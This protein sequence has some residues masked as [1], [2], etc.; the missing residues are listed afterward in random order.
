MRN[1][2]FI[3]YNIDTE[4]PLYESLTATFERINETFGLSIE[5]TI[6]NLK[7]LQNGVSPQ[8]YNIEPKILNSIKKFVSPKL[9]NHKNDW[10]ELKKMWDIAFSDNFRNN[11]LFLDSK[12]QGIIYN[13]FI[14]DHIGFSDVN[15]RRRT[16]G[17]NGVFD[18]YYDLISQSKSN[19]K[20]YW[21]FHPLHFYKQANYCSTTLVYSYKTLYSSLARKIIDKNYFPCAF[22]AGFHT[23]RQDIHNFLEMWIPFDFSN[24]A[25][26]TI[27]ETDTVQ[28]D[29]SNGRFGDWRRAPY[30]WSVYHPSHDDYETPGNCRRYIAK[31]LNIGTRLREITEDEI[32]LCFQHSIDNKNSILAFTNHDWRDIRD[33]LKKVYRMIK[34]ISKKYPNVDLINSSATTALRNYLK[35][36]DTPSFNWECNTEY[37]Q[38]TLI[39]NINILQGHLFGP[40]PFL[41]IK[42]LE[43]NYIYENFVIDQPFKKFKYIFDNFTYS[44]NIIDTIG[45]ATCDIDGFVHI[46]KIKNNNGNFIVNKINVNSIF[47]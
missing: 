46:L 22:R 25:T 41:A 39:I 32:E 44:P 26:K 38:N 7:M 19:D 18:F 45:I 12:N 34:K 40:Q 27:C 4:G 31:C 1:N 43:N 23:E 3:V 15:P 28:K 33:D 5:P 35:L 37:Y 42:T 2:L 24:Q 13:F 17:H 21:H 16:I 20:L 10:T 8:G 9:L 30:D 14:L 29:I 47:Q 6:T 11:K 36:N